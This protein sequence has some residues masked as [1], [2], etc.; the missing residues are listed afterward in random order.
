M[1]QVSARQSV[2]KVQFSEGKIKAAA[3]GACLVV[4]IIRLFKAPEPNRWCSTF[5][6]SAAIPRTFAGTSQ[7]NVD[8]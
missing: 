7:A 3:P 5:C 6:G 1:S 8:A 2:Q 4:E